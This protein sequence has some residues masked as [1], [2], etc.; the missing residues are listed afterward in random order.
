VKTPPRDAFAAFVRS[1]IEGFDTWDVG[2]EFYSL[3]WDGEKITVG[4]L[5]MIVFNVPP[6]DIPGQICRLAFEAINNPKLDHPP[7]AYA[8]RTEGYGLRK[9]KPTD[10]ARA[11]ADY[12]EARV[13][14]T[15]HKH[16]QAKEFVSVWCVDIHC[17]AWS[18]SLLRDGTEPPEFAFHGPNDQTGP[19][20][21]LIRPLYG[22]AVATGVLVHGLAPPPGVDVNLP[23]FS[24]DFSPN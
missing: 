4:L 5:A 7:Y 20:G 8:L 19:Q 2:H 16:P 21:Q 14:R 15:F 9:P 3:H 24:P 18:G 12:H 23:D 17:R 6:E 10:P 13:N 22:A 1:T 11:H